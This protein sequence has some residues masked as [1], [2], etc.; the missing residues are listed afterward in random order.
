VRW[1]PGGF[2]DRELSQRQ[3]A[4][5]PPASRLATITGEPGAVDEALALLDVPAD[6]EV[7]GPVPVGDRSDPE[8]R[9]VIRVPRARGAALSQSLGQLQRL[10]SSRKLDAVR[11]QVDPL[12]L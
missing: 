7:V 9:L 2:A 3:Q 1:D 4:H 6:A 11:I 10:R 8:N 12:T 5:L